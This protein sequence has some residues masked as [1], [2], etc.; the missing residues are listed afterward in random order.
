MSDTIFRTTAGPHWLTLLNPVRMAANL[1]SHRGLIY[2]FARRDVTG[3]YRGSYL[4]VLWAVLS[5]LLLLAVY[6]VIFSVIF[7]LKFGTGAASGP[8]TF[9]IN[10][11]IAMLVFNVFAEVANRSPFLVL[12]NPNLVKKVVFPLESLVPAALLSSLVTMGVGLGV[13]LVGRCVLIGP[14]SWSTLLMPV[15]ILPVCLTTLGLGWFLAALGVFVRDIGHTI[16]VIVQVLFL[17]TPIFYSVEMLEERNAP[18]V[19]VTLVRLNPLTQAAEQAREVALD[20]RLPQWDW[21][22]A[23]LVVG[24]IVA[25]LGYAFF[26]K[27]RR[28]FADVI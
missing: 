28:A 20:S 23:M 13:W 22:A 25:V 1:L 6:T 17:L 5:P 14:P 11:F 24:V 27:S 18:R 2:Q 7:E 3:K 8:G 10:M 12:Q 26:M 16:A 9:A 4:G 19:C 15:V 21:W